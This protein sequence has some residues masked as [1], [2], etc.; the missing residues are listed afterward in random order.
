MPSPAPPR[1]SVIKAVVQPP[2]L[3]RASLPLAFELFVP[4][5]VGPQGSMPLLGELGAT[6]PTPPHD[7]EVLAVL[8]PVD[9]VLEV[10][11]GGLR[12]VASLSH[13]APGF[14]LFFDRGPALAP[15]FG[16]KGRPCAPR[17]PAGNFCGLEDEAQL[18]RLVLSGSGPRLHGKVVARAD[19]TPSFP[20]DLGATVRDFVLT[21]FQA[22]EAGP[23]GVK[24]AAALEQSQKVHPVL[25]E[26]EHVPVRSALLGKFGAWV[27]ERAHEIVLLFYAQRLDSR[28]A[29]LTTKNPHPLAGTFGCEA[30]P[31]ADCAPQ[32]HPRMLTHRVEQRWGAEVALERR[33]R[34]DGT[35]VA[36]RAR[37]SLR[38]PEPS[39]TRRPIGRDDSGGP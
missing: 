36:E 18:V 35:I 32:N 24:L 9:I 8:A 21:A 19:R 23:L 14:R 7:V 13:A 20:L 12:S 27:D 25:A 33:L 16:P 22:A 2:P 37:A 10:T 28:F 3:V 34:P 5:G 1:A 30:P 39:I 31:G 38:A 4:E 17:P 29:V 11:P 26:L 6:F 15:T